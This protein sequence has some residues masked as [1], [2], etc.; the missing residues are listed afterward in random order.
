[1]AGEKRER[2]EPGTSKR[3]VKRNKS[4]EF[5]EVDEVGKSLTALQ[6]R[7]YVWQFLIGINSQINAWGQT[8]GKKEEH[9]SLPRV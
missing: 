7:R 1:M 9:L 5:K 4:G 3:F 2:I 6:F 8:F